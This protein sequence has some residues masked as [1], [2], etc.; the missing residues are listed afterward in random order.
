[1]DIVPALLESDLQQF[2]ERLE[3]L[4]SFASRVQVDFNDGN[5]ENTKTLLPEEIKETVLRYK[6]KIFFEAHLMVQ[7][8]LDLVPKLLES[9]FKKIIIQYE[10][11]GNL[12]EIFEQ[13]M[14]DEVL[15]G[16]AIGPGTSIY[17]ADPILELV[18]TVN[19]LD[20]EPGKQ[21]QGFLPEQ[22]EKVKQLREMNFLGEIQVDGAITAETVGKVTEVRPNTL[23]VGHYIVAADDPREKFEQLTSLIEGL[24]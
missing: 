1:M 20:I 21:G 2:K 6:H 17:D 9:G 16:A 14:A 7:K 3:K 11:E 18:D 10:I 24:G 22:L 19:V 5:F 23:V 12:R 4:S 15:V 13:L 8:P